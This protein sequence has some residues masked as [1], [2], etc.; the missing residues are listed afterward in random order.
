MTKTKVVH[1]GAVRDL[2]AEWE[3]VR[4]FIGTGRMKGFQLTVLD[5]DERETVFLGGV[6]K[7]DS[8]KALR[9]SLKMSA[10]RMLAEDEPLLKVV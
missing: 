7:D 6:Y 4:Q 10:A 1:L 2:Q 5:E 3:K 8:Q 9:A